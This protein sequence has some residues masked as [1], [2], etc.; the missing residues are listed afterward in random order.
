MVLFRSFRHELD[1]LDLEILERAFD[2]TWAAFKE[3]TP[4]HD[5]DS[6]EDLEAA[7]R[8]E[9]IEIAHFNWRERPRRNPCETSLWVGCGRSDQRRKPVH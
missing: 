6:D 8:R 1:P 2:A 4:P 9:L 7:L 5:F 3:N